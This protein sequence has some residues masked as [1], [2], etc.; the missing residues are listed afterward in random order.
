MTTLAIKPQEHI[1][2]YFPT[3]F[4]TKCNQHAVRCGMCGVILYVDEERFGFFSDAINA[5]LD[6]PFRC[7]KCEQEYDDLAYEG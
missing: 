3:A 1:T 6:S 5:G 4:K 2:P 7:E